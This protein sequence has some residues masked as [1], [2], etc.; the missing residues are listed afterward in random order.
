MDFH[1]RFLFFSNIAFYFP[2]DVKCLGGALWL[3]VSYDEAAEELYVIVMNQYILD[4]L[5]KVKKSNCKWLD[6]FLFDWQSPLCMLAMSK[7][8]NIP[9]VLDIY[10]VFLWHL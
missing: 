5:G 10:E 8:K 4:D 1:S 6:I 7:I 3:L 2:L 9:I